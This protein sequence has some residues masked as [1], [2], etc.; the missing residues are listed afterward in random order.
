MTHRIPIDTRQIDALLK[1]RGW[2]RA[3][4]LECAGI[5]AVAL[6]EAEMAG[7]AP[8]PLACA[9]ADA[10]DVAP[11]VLDARSP[12]ARR[13][14]ER[15]TAWVVLGLLALFL[16]TMVFGYRVGADLAARDNRAD[17]V[18]ASGND[19]DAQPGGPLS[20]R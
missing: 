4:L 8:L 20:T 5:D 17:C 14:H 11:A 2:P 15:R 16:M 13:W 12:S 6:R 7:L 19:C 18:A 9:L 3:R 1:A 10:L